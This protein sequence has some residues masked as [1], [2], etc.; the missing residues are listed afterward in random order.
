MYR[1]RS[2]VRMLR[3][4]TSV[5]TNAAMP[6]AV[7]TACTA[8]EIAVEARDGDEADAVEQERDRQQRRVG[9]RREAAHREVRDDVEAEHRE[10]GTPRGRRGC[11]GGRR[12]A[13]ARSRRR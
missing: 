11:R 9:A 3:T 7:H 1:Y 10:R 8:R 4:T 2:S 12:A 6:T 13:A 5:S